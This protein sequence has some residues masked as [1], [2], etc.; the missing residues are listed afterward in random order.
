M[1]ALFPISPGKLL[2]EEFLKPFS[3]T[4]HRLATD[5]GGPPQ[6]IGDI[7]AVERSIITDTDLGLCRCFGLSD[8]Y[9]SNGQVSRDTAIARTTVGEVL[10]QISRCLLLADAV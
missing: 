5:I 6:R 10:A 8:G 2:D 4:P 7:V 1:R 3:L 9:G